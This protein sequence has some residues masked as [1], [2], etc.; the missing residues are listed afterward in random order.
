MYGNGLVSQIKPKPKSNANSNTKSKRKTKTENE[1][2]TETESAFKLL[3]CATHRIEPKQLFMAK[4]K[5]G[6]NFLSATASAM[7]LSGQIGD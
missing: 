2:E 7:C 4:T 5:T 3:H 6:P 1:T